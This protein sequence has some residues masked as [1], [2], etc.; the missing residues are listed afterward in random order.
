MIDPDNPDQRPLGSPR[1]NYT[2]SENQAFGMR[3]P[4][5]VIRQT[6]GYGLKKIRQSIDGPRN[7]VDRLF[8]MVDEGSRKQLKGW[9][10]E[11][12][13]IFTDVSWPRDDVSLPMVVVEPQSEEEDVSQSLL[14]DITGVVE[15]GLFGDGRP[16]GTVTYASS[17][18]HTTN[19]YVGAQDDRL[20][21]FLYEIVKFIVLTNKRQLEEWYDIHNLIYSGQILE[22]DEKQFPTHG[23]FRVLQLTYHTFFDFSGDEVAAKIVSLDLS[24]TT[25]FDDEAQV[26]R[27]TTVIPTEDPWSD[28]FSD[29]FGG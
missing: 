23:F 27:V 10:R 18:K 25:R 17:Q 14:G 21:L 2:V 7:L 11:H 5:F 26:T 6:I 3:I 24:V 15:T 29:G 22:R 9:I 12:E 28:G 4:E 13:N 1:E 20:T 8:R 16:T 19:V